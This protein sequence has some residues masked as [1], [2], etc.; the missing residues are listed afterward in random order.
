[1]SD[2]Y[3]KLFRSIAASTIVSEPL[4]TRWLWVTM[5]SQA[6][7]AGKVYASVPGLARMAN[8]SLEECEAGLA[9]FLAP[10][11][12]SRTTEH[13]GRRIEAID[14][15]WL[16]LNHG[17]YDAMRNEA[18]RRE[19]KREWDRKN[20]PSG[21]A[22][23]KQSEAEQSDGSPSQSDETRQSGPISHSSF[24]ISQGNETVI[25]TP[26]AGGGAV[27]IEGV[28]EG[29]ANP[30]PAD[31]HPA[32]TVAIA[33]RKAG[34]KTTGMNPDLIAAVEA[35]VTVEHLLELASLHPNKPI[36]YLCRAAQ[37]ER[38]ETPAPVV[39]GQPRAG[40]RMQ[41]SKTALGIASLEN[42]KNEARQHM[43]AGGDCDGATE[44][45]GALAGPHAGR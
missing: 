9:C 44:A 3:T 10:D 18:E 28:F 39:A 12:Y 13:E 25:P 22:R 16:L 36:A 8:I 17:K 43:A 19:K 5:L 27:V 30:K 21:H 7:K 37:R 29:H 38:A 34:I 1:M 4:A 15:G 14:G 33:L 32:T 41:P 42:L 23:A 20:R 2:T 11:R 26:P 35:G 40:P 45:R 31:I 24:P 6:D